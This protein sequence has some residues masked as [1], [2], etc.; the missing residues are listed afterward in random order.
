MYETSLYLSVVFNSPTQTT[1]ILS[2]LLP[3]LYQTLPQ[4]PRTTSSTTLL[5]ALHFL[6][7]EYPSQSRCRELLG[8]VPP[9]FF[10]RDSPPHRWISEVM[11]S[12]RSHNFARFENLTNQYN[13]RTLLLIGEATEPPCPTRPVPSSS[14]GTQKGPADL[15]YFAFLTLLDALRQRARETA[16]LVIR[17][18]YRELHCRAPDGDESQLVKS[19]TCDWLYRALSLR[20]LTIP[21]ECRDVGSDD[22]QVD[23]VVPKW[24]ERRCAQGEVR[25][26]EGNEGRWIV[27][28]PAS[29]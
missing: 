4:I 17:S 27:C 28:K 22:E 10:P 21:V 7:T 18:A 15:S 2:H 24:L 12:L 6:V 13:L 29:T 25:R 16:W 9:S 20:A 8:S 11:Q 14:Q 1:T 26:K 3:D 19:P 23:S 5:S